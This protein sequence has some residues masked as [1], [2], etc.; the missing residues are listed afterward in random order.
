MSTRIRFRN[1]L[2]KG[3]NRQPYLGRGKE[4]IA[5]GKV[6]GGKDGTPYPGARWRQ[7]PG[8]GKVYP[9]LTSKQVWSLPGGN[10]APEPAGNQDT[11]GL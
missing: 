6:H 11:I 2:L 1:E 10:A 9:R 4:G 7:I 3:W 8:I 5:F